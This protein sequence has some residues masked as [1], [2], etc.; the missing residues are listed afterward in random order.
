[1]RAAAAPVPSSVVVP[2]D[3]RVP[4]DV[5]VFSSIG[6]CAPLCSVSNR[7]SV[8]VVFELS[9]PSVVESVTVAA[10]V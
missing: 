2:E 6:P 4:L 1:M 9:V 8:S 3:W 5:T 10:V 7:V